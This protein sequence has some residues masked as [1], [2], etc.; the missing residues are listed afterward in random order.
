[1]YPNEYIFRAMCEANPALE[2]I[3][4][5]NNV[6][7]LNGVSVSLEN[8]NLQEIYGEY[9]QLKADIISIE[10]KDL[11]SIIQINA[12]IKD[13]EKKKAMDLED[14]I[15]QV[16]EV[17]PTISNMNIINKEDELGTERQYVQIVTSDGAD[18]VLYNHTPQD[19]MDALK[20]IMEKN[21]NST[22]GITE[23]DL[24]AELK[25]NM[26]EIELVDSHD[27]TNSYKYSEEFQNKMKNMEQNY[28]G[29]DFVLGNEEYDIYLA[30]HEMTTYTT[31]DKGMIQ[32]EKH[33]GSNIVGGDYS[34]NGENSNEVID[35]VEKID[36]TNLISVE[37]YMQLTSKDFDLNQD[38][39]NKVDFFQGFVFELKTYK[40]YLV[41]D[42][43]VILN[44][45][46]NYITNLSLQEELNQNQENALN[47]YNESLDKIPNVALKNAK[48][49]ALI[50]EYKAKMANQRESIAGFANSILIVELTFV[51][52]ITLSALIIYFFW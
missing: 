15:E 12:A 48:N 29:S 19:V 36:I 37:E 26:S 21:G 7:T 6:I 11:F 25:R 32:K 23:N 51:L 3:T 13:N 24:Y 33:E 45:Y 41:E 4:L 35:N 52:S 1:M 47:N 43:L 50:L 10:P 46:E 20:R 27:V 28:H 49:K 16:K 31:N 30:G 40:D 14:N 5:E 8:L 18:H 2:V 39:Q 42:G 17:A 22:Q 9:S 34:S 38:E 44:K